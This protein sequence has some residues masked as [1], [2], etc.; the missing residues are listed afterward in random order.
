MALCF[1]YCLRR[2]KFTVIKCFVLIMFTTAAIIGLICRQLDDSEHRH[3]RN[4]EARWETENAEQDWQR[5]V[6]AN[7]HPP[8]EIAK[9]VGGMEPPMEP[10]RSAELLTTKINAMSVPKIILHHEMAKWNSEME[11]RQNKRLRH[12]DQTCQDVYQT[13]PPS[14]LTKEALP[15]NAKFDSTYFNDDFKFFISTSYN[16][17]ATTIR[18]ALRDLYKNVTLHRTKQVIFHDRDFTLNSLNNDDFDARMDVFFKAIFVRNPLSRLLSAYRR[19]ILNTDQTY[20]Q[21]KAREIVQMYRKNIQK[22]NNMDPDKPSFLEFVQYVVEKDNLN[23]NWSPVVPRLQSCYIPYDFI[24]KLETIDTDSEDLLKTLGI[25]K[26]ISFEPATFAISSG[27]VKLIRSNYD[28]L[29]TEVFKQVLNIYQA[30]FRVFGYRVPLNQTDI[31]S[32]EDLV[33]V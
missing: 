29:T 2:R 4:A 17:A 23:P 28:T 16:V 8:V 1:G 12:K 24:G 9:E 11:N 10:V 33:G 18:N 19:K 7:T 13:T 14:S 6:I 20:Y 27:D 5:N 22:D 26:L 25:D 21:Q 3:R 30:D 31:N 32:Q 15:Q